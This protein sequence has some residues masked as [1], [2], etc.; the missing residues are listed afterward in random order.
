ML[1]TN[2]MV[3]ELERLGREDFVVNLAARDAQL[4][5]NQEEVWS[6][7]SACLRW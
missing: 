6:C 7:S 5:Q 4:S 1:E 3:P 2:E